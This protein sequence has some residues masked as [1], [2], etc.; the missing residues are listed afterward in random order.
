M[1][2]W[3]GPDPTN[4]GC[5]CNVC[6]PDT[7]EYYDTTAGSVQALTDVSVTITG[8][9]AG[10]GTACDPSFPCTDLNGVFQV[11]CGDTLNVSTCSGQANLA[12]TYSAPTRLGGSVFVELT[13]NTLS[14]GTTK[15]WEFSFGSSLCDGVG[16]VRNNSLLSPVVLSTSTAAVPCDVITGTNA[17][18]VLL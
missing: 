12:I 16:L 11:A 10:T 15:S 5:E 2:N 9:T 1:P 3:F 8:V 17:T 4:C 18:A 6:D 13:S 7:C 14:I